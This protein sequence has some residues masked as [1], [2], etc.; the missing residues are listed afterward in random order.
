MPFLPAMT[1]NGNH[2]TYKD[3]DGWGTVQ[4]LMVIK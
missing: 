4:L 1:G 2:A 3:G